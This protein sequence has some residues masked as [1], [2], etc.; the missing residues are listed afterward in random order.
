ML[1][2]CF[3]ANKNFKDL[4]ALQLCVEWVKSKKSNIIR[5]IRHEEVY[6]M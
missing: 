3:E 5:I 1:T 2:H 6:R 4:I